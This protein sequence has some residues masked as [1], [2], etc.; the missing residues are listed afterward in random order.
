MA[1]LRKKLAQTVKEWDD[2]TQSLE[3][4]LEKQKAQNEDAVEMIKEKDQRL[5]DYENL[6]NQTVNEFKEQ[7][8]D[9]E[10]ISKKF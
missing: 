10:E 8:L 5:F 6:L 9:T 3:R 1:I 2:Y 4:Q 7:G